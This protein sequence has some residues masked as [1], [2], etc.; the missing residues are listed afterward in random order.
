MRYINRIDI[1]DKDV[2]VPIDKY[3]R[4]FPNFPVFDG[5]GAVDTFA[6]NGNMP[7]ENT[8]FRLILNAGSTDSPLVK[9][10]SFLLDIDV[11]R[12]TAMPQNDDSLWTVVEEIRELKNRIFEASITDDARG[13]FS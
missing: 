5:R 9:T 8:N 12:E 11:S 3:L 10:L 4:F 2:P 6:I 7:I 1:P 13:L